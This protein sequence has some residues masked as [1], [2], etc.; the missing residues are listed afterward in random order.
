[1]K[2]ALDISFYL[3]AATVLFGAGLMAYVLWKILFR[4]PALPPLPKAREVPGQAIPEM[5]ETLQTAKRETLNT[6]GARRERLEQECLRLEKRLDKL[7]D[8]TTLEQE[9]Y[10]RA[11][12]RRETAWHKWKALHDQAYAEKKV[13][14]LKPKLRNA[15][16]SYREAE[17]RVEDEWHRAIAHDLINL[18]ELH[19]QGVLTPAEREPDG[20]PAG[21]PAAETAQEAAGEAPTESDPGAAA[22]DAA[23][24]A[25]EPEM[26]MEMEEPAG[27]GGPGLR[28]ADFR[29]AGLVAPGQKYLDPT[30]SLA[31]LEGGLLLG[32]EL[33][34]CSFAGV[35]LSGTHHHRACGY[36]GAD[37]SRIVLERAEKPHWFDD[38][39]FRGADFSAA[40]IAYAKFTRCDLS[41]TRWSGV[42]LERV[43]IDG[44]NLDGVDWGGADLS[45]A[46]ITGAAPLAPDFSSASAPPMNFRADP[47]GAADGAG[48]NAVAPAEEKPAAP[49]PPAEE[50]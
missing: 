47:P 24:P 42:D 20:P 5:R 26:E 11:L 31:D 12:K 6:S 25:A 7:I 44:C 4:P 10:Y 19:G 9:D 16:R 18:E 29:E 30:L 50:G 34:G 35:R 13:A 32:A 36:A 8:R 1:M 38:C 40:R 33:A 48:Q 28:Q 23:P 27:D 46:V 45:E 3:Y 39:N 21:P 17:R 22:D 49:P 41:H 14:E 15:E 2:L 43:K 37:F